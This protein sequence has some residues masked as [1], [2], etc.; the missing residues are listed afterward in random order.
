[1]RPWE[2]RGRKPCQEKDGLRPVGKIIIQRYKKGATLTSD[3]GPSS[4][5]G[6]RT[7]AVVAAADVAAVVV[8]AAGAPGGHHP[9]AVV[10]A[11]GTTAVVAAVVADLMVVV[12][13]DCRSST[14]PRPRGQSPRPYQRSSGASGAGPNP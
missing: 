1:V 2:R 14:R 11:A 7:P 6:S 12:M 10:V 4:G 9:Q 5:P 8:V 13:E 3:P